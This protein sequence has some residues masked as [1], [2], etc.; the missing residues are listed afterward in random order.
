MKV[1]LISIRPKWCL[2]ISELEKT[3][4]VRKTRPKIETPFK[5][6]IYCTKDA[7]LTKSHSA[8]VLYVAANTKFQKALEDIG[9]VTYSGKIIGEFVC[10]WIRTAC[11]TV[12][13][14]ID[15]VD[16]SNSCL[17][18]KKILNYADGKPLELWHIS[19]LIIY[20][21]PKELSKFGLTR[22]PQSWCYVEEVAE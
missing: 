6:Y 14:L 5:A 16:C 13:G 19:E 21:K 15:V 17:S 9:N 11:E 20:D 7:L 22:A 8:G 10:D 18:A 12:D 3:I 1:V 4:E 2:L